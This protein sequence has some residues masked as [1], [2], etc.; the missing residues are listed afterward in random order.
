MDLSQRCREHWGFKA[1]SHP[2]AKSI[3]DLEGLFVW[4]AFDDAARRITRAIE[5]RRFLVVVGPACSAKSTLWTEVKR[6]EAESQTITNVCEPKGLSPVAYDE[7]TI[8]RC[9]VRGMTTSDTP[10]R[11]S[12]EDRAWQVRQLLEQ[13]NASKTAVILT[14]NDA[15]LCRQEFLLLCKRLWDDLYGFDR[16]LSVIFIAQPK[17]LT[18]IAD[19]P[20]I[21]ERT[22]ILRMPGLGD[23]LPE[24]LHHEC[25]RAGAETFPFDATA[26][27]L[28]KTL[29]RENWMASR[30][31]PLIVNNIASRALHMAFTVKDKAVTESHVS[32]AIRAEKAMTYSDDGDDEGGEKNNRS[33][34]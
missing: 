24:Y 1:G 27:G 8:Y 9:L 32:E 22:D 3:Q 34:R 30:D 20:E 4:P 33:R 18:T 12:R 5:W 28:L 13:S 16:L 29:H 31:H 21:S 17:I 11:R 19:C 10:L 25:T 26:V 15:H 7:Q 14:I 6:R 23:Y 2:F